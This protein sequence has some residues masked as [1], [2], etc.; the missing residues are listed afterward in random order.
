MTRSRA[1][2]LRNRK[3]RIEARL[4]E[5]RWKA[6]ERP[7]LRARNIRYDVAE[8]SRGL[9]MGGIGA[10]HD[11]ARRTGLI[12]AIDEKLEVLKIHLPYHESDHVLNIAYNALCG[13]T[14]LEDLELWRN[15][16]VYLDALGAQRIPD[17]TT[18]GD[19]CRRLDTTKVVELMEATNETRLKVWAQ[20]PER[21]FKEAIIDV[22]GTIAST[23]GECKEGMDISFKGEW[24][25]H[26]LLVSL[27]NTQEPLYLVNRRGNRPSHDGATPWIDDAITLVRRGGFKSVLL[28]GDTDFTQTTELDRWD[29]DGVRFVFG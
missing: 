21:F 28:R 9:A 20:Q 25:Y 18:A 17:P 10:I 13:G 2:K 3:R 4:R 6:Q 16:E 29:E 22:D 26:P 27:A 12:E 7:M 23:T 24:G 19:F 8:R 5:R 14:C 1:R 11:L 15:D